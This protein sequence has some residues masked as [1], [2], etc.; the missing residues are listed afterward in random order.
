M[1]SL[2]LGEQRPTTRLESVAGLTHRPPPTPRPQSTVAPAGLPTTPPP[3]HLLVQMNGWVI[4]TQE[5]HGLQ[6]I[7][8]LD[9]ESKKL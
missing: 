2:V 8:D 6:L 3:P 5:K 4:P 7:P 9:P 1:Q